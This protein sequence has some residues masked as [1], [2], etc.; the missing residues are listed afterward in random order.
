MISDYNKKV[1]VTRPAKPSQT[2][3]GGLVASKPEDC[4]T[5]H[6]QVESRTGSMQ[7]GSSMREWSYDYKLTGRYTKSYVEKGGDLIKYGEKT[8]IVRTVSFDNEGAPREVVLRCSNN[9]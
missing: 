8:L 3:G 9:E 7:T 4:F 2:A 1:T 6:Y 5:K